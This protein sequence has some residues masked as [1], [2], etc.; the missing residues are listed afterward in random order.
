MA[1]K[2]GHG[3]AG[4]HFEEKIEQA[5]QEEKQIK[6]DLEQ[7]RLNHETVRSAK[8][9]IGKVYHPYNL[10]TGQKTGF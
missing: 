10:K 4:P 9:E 2:N 1:L 3:D 6:K 5:K 7:A 8:A